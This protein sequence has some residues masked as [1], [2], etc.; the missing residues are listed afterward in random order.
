[1]DLEAGELENKVSYCFSPMLWHFDASCVKEL[2]EGKVK[3]G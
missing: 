1:M 2:I 3:M